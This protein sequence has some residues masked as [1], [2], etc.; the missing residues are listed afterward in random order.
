M[1]RGELVS[2]CFD[3]PYTFQASTFQMAVLLQFNSN[4][5]LTFSQLEESTGIRSDIL[6]Q[7]LQALVSKLRVLKSADDSSIISMTSSVSLFMGYKNKK[8]KV[9]INVPIKSEVKSEQETVH[10]HVEED[11]KLLIQAAIVRI[12][13]IR[14]IVKH[15]IL[16]SE[17]LNQLSSRF[18]PKIP[19][20]KKCIDILIE[21]EYLKR[22]EKDSY[23]YVA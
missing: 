16:L 6:L 10:R 21:K 19:I 15:H 18:K 9:N 11:R 17:V 4:D 1:S 23:C 13:K 22:V 20:I 12:A 3:K 8:L 7:V 2:K 14:K 5:T